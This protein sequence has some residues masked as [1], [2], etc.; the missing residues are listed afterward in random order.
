M[1][2]GFSGPEEFR[3]WLEEHHA[4]VS[5]LIIRCWKT[6]AK[7]RGMT[8]RQALD[9]ALCVGWIDGVRRSVD[10][11]SFSVRFTPRRSK[12]PWSAIN[13]ARASQLQAEGRMHPAGLAAWE[14]GKRAHRPQETRGGTLAPFY[15]RKLRA[16]PRAWRFIEE[17]PPSYRRLC[18][19]WVM[20]AKQP[21]TRA[22][23]LEVLIASSERQQ[24]IPPLGRAAHRGTRGRTRG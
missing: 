5:E 18:A 1:P 13:M 9:E 19:L 21:E 11:E 4:R 12:S 22:R 20:S 14:A 17:Q 7:H 6:R 10:A 15:L 2:R 16:R 3:A 23:R 24:A 8:Y